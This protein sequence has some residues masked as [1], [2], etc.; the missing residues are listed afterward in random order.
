VN[1]EHKNIIISGGGTGG[2]VF[3][4]IAI[5][6]ALKRRNP[7]INILFVGALGKMEMEKVPAAGYEIIGLPVTGLKRTFT[8]KNVGVIINL[9]RS[10]LKAKRIIKT[11]KPDAVVGVGGYASGPVLNVAARR[12][13]PTLI[14]EQN[15]YAGITNKILAKKA[16]KICVAYE[17]M[18]R[19]F[20]KSKIVFT[21]NPVRDDLEN[22]N[23]KREAGLVHFGLNPEL[24]VILI[25]GGSL[26]AQTINESVWNHLDLISDSPVQFIWQTG[27]LYYHQAV[28]KING[29]HLR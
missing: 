10:I 20:P 13:I 2:H 7:G 16:D 19:F 8:L 27:K 3:P 5:A 21:G 17:G 29:V 26:G 4:A 22:I 28:E 23:G 18:D 25:L 11:F 9:L 1:E 6:Q 12:K 24:P 15:S 14:Q